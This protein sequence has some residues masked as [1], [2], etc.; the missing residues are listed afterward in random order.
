MKLKDIYKNR[1]NFF[2][3]AIII[4]IL[5]QN[6]VFEKLYTIYKFSAKERLTKSYGYCEGASYG[7][8]DDIFKENTINKNIEILNDNPNF[9]FNNSIWFKFKVDQPTSKKQVIL[10][11]NKNSIEFFDNEKVRLIFKN[12]DYGFYKVVKKFDNCYFL[13]ND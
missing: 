7:F 2:L 4:F 12:K 6:N 1:I 9:S 8:I 3:V 5:H 10:L 13:K 11:N